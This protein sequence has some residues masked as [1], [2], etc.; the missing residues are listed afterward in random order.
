MTRGTEAKT[1][2]PPRQ[3]GI[4]RRVWNPLQR[5]R[6]TVNLS[7]TRGSK[8]EPEDSR[9]LARCIRVTPSLP[10]P[11]SATSGAERRCLPFPGLG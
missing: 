7:V 11:A 9:N 2:P 3:G 1:D 6:W 10:N 8:R 5:V 4:Y